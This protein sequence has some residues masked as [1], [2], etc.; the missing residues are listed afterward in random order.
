MSRYRILLIDDDP[1]FRSLIMA[2]LRKDYMVSVAS[3]GF[4]GFQKGLEHPPHL[5]VIDVQMPVWDGLKTLKAFHIHP[6]LKNVPVMMLTSDASKETVL[7]SIH[8]GAQG[9]II[10][11]TFCKEDFLKKVHRLLGEDDEPP[12]TADANTAPHAELQPMHESWE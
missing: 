4:D 6:T 2:L 1:L 10:K 11:S 9:Y 7:A 12:T 5:A 3:N 8:A